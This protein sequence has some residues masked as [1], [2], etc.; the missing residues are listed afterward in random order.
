MHIRKI[1]IL[2]TVL[3]L[4]ISNAWAASVFFNPAS[5]SVV[6]GNSVSVDLVA[7]L[8]NPVLGWG[9]D[10][11]F[12]AALLSLTNVAIDPS[13]FAVIPPDGDFLAG[14]AFPAPITG[15]NVVLATLTFN[16]LD[17]GTSALNASI[18]PL[19]FTEGFPLPPPALPGSF[20]A[21]NFIAG[22][23]EVTGSGPAPVPEPST[24]LLMAS[25]LLGLAAWRMKTK[26]HKRE[27]DT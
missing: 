24:I 4:P 11:S 19:D 1:F 2:L 5:Q 17:V 18:T 27:N 16:T 6:D 23:I 10:V 8:P 9:L 20:D 14:L 13:W 3:Y 7:D 12:D 22:S 26:K 21:V 15:N 25:G